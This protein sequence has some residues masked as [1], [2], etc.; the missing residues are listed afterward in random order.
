MLR[1]RE[2]QVINV[3]NA[4]TVSALGRKE[5]SAGDSL[6]LTL[7]QAPPMLFSPQALTHLSDLLIT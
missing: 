6:A 3:I 5:F 2:I 1:R 7:N 4:V